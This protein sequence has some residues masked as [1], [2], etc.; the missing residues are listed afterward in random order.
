MGVGGVHP[1]CSH[2]RHKVSSLAHCSAMT[3][4]QPQKQNHLIMNGDVHQ[5]DP[6]E[7]SFFL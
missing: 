2:P 1:L 5:C 3:S 7:N 6:K 4:S